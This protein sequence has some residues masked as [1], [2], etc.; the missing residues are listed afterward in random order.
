MVGLAQ[1]SQHATPRL[2]HSRNVVPFPP[3]YQAE[4]GHDSFMICAEI[5]DSGSD[6]ARRRVE[7]ALR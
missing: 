1:G 2:Q 6:I 3:A 5:T 7:D 4:E